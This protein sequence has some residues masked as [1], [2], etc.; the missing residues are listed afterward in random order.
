MR[1]KK[2]DLANYFLMPLLEINRKTYQK[3]INSYLSSDFKKLVV[4]LGADKT[5]E[6]L[7]INHP[8]YETDF[9]DDDNKTVVIF[10]IPDEFERTINQFVNGQYSKFSESVKS[11]IRKFS[12]LP[13]KQKSIKNGQTNY[14]TARPLMALDLNPV[15]KKSVEEQI[16]E[17][18]PKGAELLSSLYP[19]D[20]Y[21][22]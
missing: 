17:E 7:Y 21:K 14:N 16:G 15:L 12:G 22:L 4:K 6:V 19:E 18:L 20:Y 10:S 5:N 2:N 13:Y 11:K 1:E 8:N 9:T 3:F